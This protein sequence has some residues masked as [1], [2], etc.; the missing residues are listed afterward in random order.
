MAG[1]PLKFQSVKEL[2]QKIDEYFRQCLLNKQI[3]TNGISH[4]EPFT[5]TGLALA[6][7]TTRKTLMEYEEKDEFSNA[8]KLAKTKVEA[9]AER[10]LFTGSATGPIFALKN[11]G[12]KDTSQQEISGR[13]GQPIQ[14]KNTSDNDKSIIQQYMQE[15]K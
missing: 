6:L 1:R 12:W 8:I 3:D 10:K 7:D 9:Y 5:I 14:I 11:Y 13:D 4:H 15:N 2:Q